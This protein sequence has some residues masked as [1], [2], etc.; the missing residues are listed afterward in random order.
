MKIGIDVGNVII[1][2]TDT[3]TSFF[4]DD[5]LA[6][7]EVSGAFDAI[8]DLIEQGHVVRLVTKCG[9]WTMERTY[10]W[11]LHHGFFEHTTL[12]PYDIVYVKNRTDKVHIARGLHLDMFVDDREDIILSLTDDVEYPILF[13][14]WCETMREVDRVADF[15]SK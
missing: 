9:K 13:S 8:R 6:T 10:Q 3:D 11:L 14:S 5:Y 12:R 15:S 2:G 1:H 7:P 4:E